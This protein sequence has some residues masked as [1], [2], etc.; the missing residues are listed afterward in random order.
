MPKAY[1]VWTGH[2]RG[3]FETWAECQKA[4]AGFPGAKYKSFPTLEEAKAAYNPQ[5]PPA[6]KKT[7]TPASKTAPQF[8]VFRRAQ[9]PVQIFSDGACNP[10]PGPGASAVVVLSQGQVL[11]TWL[12]GFSDSSTN[13][14]AELRALEQALR[15]AQQFAEEGLQVEILSDSQYSL[16]SVFTWGPGW[17]S[18]GWKKKDGEIANLELIQA[19]YGL[20]QELSPLVQ[21][22]HVEGHSGIQGNELADQAAQEALSRKVLS[23]ERHQGQIAPESLGDAES[24]LG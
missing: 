2:Q 13:N 23:W 9:F 8:E 20:S 16:R 10:N 21:V 1:V 24:A 19:C 15:L 5:R 6:V 14:T 3:V 12:G 4:T 18:R 11:E 17:E 22:T 7:P